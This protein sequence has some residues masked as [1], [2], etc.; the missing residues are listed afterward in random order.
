MKMRVNKTSNN[1]LNVKK[2]KLKNLM[3]QLKKKKLTKPKNNYKT[4]NLNPLI[5][6]N[7]QLMNR[8]Y[9]LVDYKRDS[10]NQSLII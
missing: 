9:Y 3:K 6:E 1:T 5:L 4:S 10:I 7:G 2:K 8:P